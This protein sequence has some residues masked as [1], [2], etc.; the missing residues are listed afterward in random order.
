MLFI[1]GQ[2]NVCIFVRVDLLLTIFYDWYFDIKSTKKKKNFEGLNTYSVNWIQRYLNLPILI[3][4]KW[5]LTI[6]IT[7]DFKLC[8]KILLL[9]TIT[10][11]HR[12]ISV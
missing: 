9:Q 11:S 3:K 12:K 5:E 2:L 4:T 6:V 10:N 1:H 8:S 7:L